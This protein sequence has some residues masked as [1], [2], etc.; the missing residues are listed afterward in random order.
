M[1][2]VRWTAKVDA[3][4]IEPLQLAQLGFDA[5]A[6]DQIGVHLEPGG[7]ARSVEV[8]PGTADALKLL[9]IELSRYDAGVT[10]KV[11]GAGSAVPITGPQLFSGGATAL[12]AAAIATLEFAEPSEAVDVRL[13]AV[14][15]ATP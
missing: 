5:E 14:R 13:L 11:N 2:K 4:G 15:D 8:H 9:A 6:I 1:P 3:D 12:F 10:Y 7:G